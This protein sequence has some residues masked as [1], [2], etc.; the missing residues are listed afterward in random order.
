MDGM[1]AARLGAVVFIA[2]AITAAV[3]EL[4]RK[5]ERPQPTPP[6]PAQVNVESPLQSELLRCQRLGE[7]GP[8]DP[9]CL[10]AWAENRRRFLTPGA[11]T[12]TTDQDLVPATGR[13][14]QQAGGIE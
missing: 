13:P 2:V 10:R 14:G 5:D 4:R 8:R 6:R 11:T 3:V 7:A 9:A 12:V 1:M